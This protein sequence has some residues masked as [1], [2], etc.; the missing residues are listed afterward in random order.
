MAKENKLNLTAPV[1]S[2]FEFVSINDKNSCTFECLV[3]KKIDNKR[4]EVKSI[5]TTTSNL[6]T[7]L[8]RHHTNEYSELE[9][10]E[11]NSPLTQSKK[12]KID[13]T[14]DQPDLVS[15]G[16]I[17]SVEKYKKN[18]NIFLRESLKNIDK[19]SN[20]NYTN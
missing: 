13:F 16:A 6:R 14:L 9:K 4:V 8:Q 17:K 5:K 12:R 20:Q 11:F 2:Y 1:Y 15:M 18:S 10:L 7:Y 3:C 19:N